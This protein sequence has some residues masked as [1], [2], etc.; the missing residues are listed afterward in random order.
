[1]SLAGA[2][3]ETGALTGAGEAFLPKRL[4]PLFAGAEGATDVLTD[5]ER[6][7]LEFV[8]AMDREERLS[9]DGGGGAE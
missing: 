6:S 4:K 5:F 8:S 3:E 9:R 7:T 1:M 2:A